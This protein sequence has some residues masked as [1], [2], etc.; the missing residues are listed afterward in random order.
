MKVLFIG[1][2]GTISSACS[3]LAVERGIDLYLLN[4]GRTNERPVP[5]GA[6]VLTGDVRAPAAVEAALGALTF[7]VV[8][9]WVAYTPAHVETDIALFR[10]RTRQYIFISTA[11]AYHKPV[12]S[13]PITEST[14]L[15]NP[16]WRYSQDKMAC[17]ERLLRAYRDQGFPLT[18]VRPSHTYDRTRLPFRGRWTI[19]ERMR[20]GLP[21]V[22][23]GD[24]T[25]LWVLTHHQDFAKGFV[26]LLGNA[27]AIGET[28]HITSDEVLTWD[29]IFRIV[30]RAAGAGEPELVHVP[31]DLIHAF[32]PEWGVGLLGDKTHSV[33]FDNTKIKRLVPGFAATIPFSQGAEEI[34]AWF[35]EDPTRQIIDEEHNR[36]LDTMISAYRMLWS[37]PKILKRSE[38]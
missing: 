1:G 2:T 24:G 34:I 26:G 7:D 28:Y 16:F 21:V 4:R 20:Q 9:D 35:E 30:A 15:H 12:H 22:V 29:Q 25:S 8:V 37:N 13:L 3:Q 17:E 33:I 18:I 11:S 10:E 36:L 6:T 14:P 32:D 38:Q 5:A 31:S 23:H 19:V 27:Q